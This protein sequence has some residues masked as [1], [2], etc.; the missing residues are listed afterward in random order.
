MLSRL[1]AVRTSEVCSSEYSSA[2]ITAGTPAAA[3]LGALT[4]GFSTPIF[5]IAF[6]AHA[7]RPNVA[8]AFDHCGSPH[9]RQRR[10]GYRPIGGANHR[11]LGPYRT[12]SSSATSVTDFLASPKSMVVVSA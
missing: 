11:E 12:L 4:F 5:S 8:I 6:R 9:N 7:G 1:I 10:V 3:C 2:C